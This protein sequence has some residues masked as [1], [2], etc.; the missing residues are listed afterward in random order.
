MRFNRPAI[1]TSVVIAV[2]A[3]SALAQETNLLALGE[4]TLPVVEPASYAGW[5]SVNM[6][7]ESPH[8]AWCS[9]S[10]H[11][12]NNVFVFEM[13]AP[14]TIDAFEFDCIV[15]GKGRGAKDLTVEVSASA[16]DAGFEKVLKASLVEGTSGQRFT[17]A[18]KVVGRW[19]RLTVDGNHGDPKY[20]ELSGIRGYGVRPVAAPAA[21]APITGTYSTNYNDFHLRQQGSAISGC[22]ER[23]KGLFEG[24]IEGRLAKI[25]WSESDGAKRGPAVFV[26]AQDGRNFQGYWWRD[27]DKGRKVDGE[28][29]GKRTSAETGSCPHWSGSVGGELQKELAAKGRARLYGILFDTDSARIRA[30]S[31]AT[32]DEVAKVLAS[33]ASW[34]LTIEGHTDSTGTA[35]HNQTLSEQRAKSVRDYLTGKGV[36]AGRLGTVGFGQTKPVADNATELGR[37][38]NRRVELVRK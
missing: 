26:F 35:A 25:T 19:V 27:T 28:W 13:L 33:E 37:A 36:A 21:I 12:V 17:V 22:Y 38:Q 1:A 16:R 20:S 3:G 31:F 6:L 11:A 23:N 32:L 7:D 24:T 8:S 5:G 34:S 4:G 18:K 14:A 15:D 2:L 30:E 9:A 10:G 29:F